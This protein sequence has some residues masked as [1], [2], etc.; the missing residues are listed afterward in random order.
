MLKFRC[1]H[2]SQKLSTRDDRAGK[3]AKCPRCKD[4]ITVP[5]P[6]AS[7]ATIAFDE[8][9]LTLIKPSK[10]PDAAAQESVERRRMEEEIAQARARDEQLLASLGV[11]L[12]S[13]P[14]H[15]GE[16]SFPWP[17]DI[18]LYPISIAGLTSMAIIVLVPFLLEFVIG[19]VRFAGMA[20]GLPLLLVSIAITIY[21]GWYLGECVYDSAKGGTR[22]RE[23]F[24]GGVGF[25]DMWSRVW[26]LI[27]VYVIYV[28]PLVIYGLLLRRTDGIFWALLAWAVIFFPMGHLAMVILDSTSALNPFMLLAAICRVFIQYVALLL[29]LAIL[30]GLA[31]VLQYALT[32]YGPALLRSLIDRTVGMYMAMVLAHVL[33]RFYWRH[34]EQL[35][36]GI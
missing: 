22:A 9:N 6:A 3:A 7:E 18:L 20:L 26:S 8:D 25:G 27:C 35:D 24:M 1:P 2:C 32:R 33:G 17:I 5:A 16:R 23:T 30:I 11:A 4:R 15:T 28:V 13:E 12:P 19:I 14:E 29:L 21:V 34:S 31:A 36:W 10:A